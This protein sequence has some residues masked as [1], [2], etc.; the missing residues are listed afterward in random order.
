MRLALQ[1]ATVL[2]DGKSCAAFIP[3][4][5]GMD[6]KQFVLYATEAH[7]I[8]PNDVSFPANYSLAPRTVPFQDGSASVTFDPGTELTQVLDRVCELCWYRWYINPSGKLVFESSPSAPGAVA[9]T[10]DQ[11]TATDMDRLREQVAAGIDFGEVVTVSYVRGRNEFGFTLEGLNADL[12]AM[13]DQTSPRYVGRALWR[14]E[15]QDDNSTPSTTSQRNL[16]RAMGQT[17]VVEWNTVGRG[18]WIRDV[19]QCDQPDIGVPVGTKFVLRGKEG[20]L[21]LSKESM[22][23]IE[24]Y[25]GDVLEGNFVE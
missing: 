8:H 17:R 23:W 10:V 16:Y 25:T 9:F 22:V 21:K 2:L 12:K 4:P 1:D 7:G 20:Q 18:L 15:F 6:L 11:A 19:V 3:F 24:Q 13:D 14:F 5:G